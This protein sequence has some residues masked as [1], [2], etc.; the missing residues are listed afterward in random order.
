M[1]SDSET[2][3]NLGAQMTTEK[4]KSRVLL[5]LESLWMRADHVREAAEFAR[6]RDTELE[7]RLVP[8]LNDAPLGM[9]RRTDRALLQDLQ[10]MVETADPEAKAKFSLDRSENHLQAL[11]LATRE[12]SELIVTAHPS[13]TSL[14]SDAATFLLRHTMIPLL[15]VRPTL[16]TQHIVAAT[17]LIDPSLPALDSAWT[18]AQRRRWKL[19]TVH[20]R[21]P[22]LP[23]VPISPFESGDAFIEPAE[24]ARRALQRAHES[25]GIERGVEG[26]VTLPP[27][28]R[29]ILE[30]ARRARAEMLVIGNH[31]RTWLRRLF[32][33][34]TCESVVRASPCSVLVVPAGV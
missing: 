7:V 26:V 10:T 30:H 19:T 9:M 4:T 27:T 11:S 14:R 18:T 8:S 22:L 16:P 29:S 32:F 20:C 21:S 12:E 23:S 28:A 25:L 5:L 17:D 15:M 24:S 13:A 1:S 6:A 33:G 3:E 2:P 34:S 31:H